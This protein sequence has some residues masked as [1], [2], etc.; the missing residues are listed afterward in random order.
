MIILGDRYEIE[1][2]AP[3]LGSG[4]MG[5]VFLGRDRQTNQSVAIKQLKQELINESPEAVERFIREADALAR[6]NHPNIVKVLATLQER[7]THY[8][9]MEYVPGGSLRSLM[10]EKGPLPLNQALHIALDLADALTRAHRLRI[11]HR[12]IKPANVLIAADGTPRLTDFGV[13]RLEDKPEMTMTGIVLGTMRYLSP[14]GL[15]G[16]PLDER[17]D[18]WSF[19]VMLYEMLAGR[20]PF[21]SDNLTQLINSILYDAPAPLHA[22]RDDV[23]AELDALILAMLV[24]DREDRISSVRQVGLELEALLRD[25]SGDSSLRIQTR[26]TLQE[27]TPTPPQPIPAETIQTEMMP[28][29]PTQTSSHAPAVTAEMGTTPA[30]VSA[31][32]AQ[33]TRGPLLVL[34]AIV[35]LALVGGLLLLLSGGGAAP[36]ATP[37]PGIVRGL[38]QYRVLVARFEPVGGVT[39]RDVSAQLVTEIRRVFTQE[40]PYALIDVVTHPEM[41]VGDEQVLRVAEAQQAALVIHGTYSATGIQVDISLGSLHDFP[42]MAFERAVLERLINVRVEIP[43]EVSQTIAPQIASGLALLA[44]ADGGVFDW[45]R[46]VAVANAPEAPAASQYRATASAEVYRFHINYLRNPQSALQSIDRAITQD[47]S[48]ALLYWLRGAALTREY[49]RDFADS[50]VDQ[51]QNNAMRDAANRNHET[52]RRL[53]PSNWAAPL[54][55]RYGGILS[56]SRFSDVGLLNSGTEIQQAASLRPNDWSPLYLLSELA[57]QEGNLEEARLYIEKALSIRPRA[58]MPYTTAAIIA[59]RSGRLVDALD[60]IQRSIRELPDPL[61]TS[62]IFDVLL[63]ISMAESVLPAIFSNLV[64][65][66]FERATQIA[67]E[68]YVGRLT[69]R[70]LFNNDVNILLMLGVSQCS[71]GNFQGAQLAFQN[72]V[73]T[74]GDF[75]LA[76]LLRASAY[77]RLNNTERAERE[78]TTIAAGPQAELLLPYVEALRQGS[79]TCETIFNLDRVRSITPEPP[80]PGT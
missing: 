47:S 4:G 16:M 36:D 44:L 15:N 67:Q 14:E 10:D 74:Q 57:L 37:T 59:L 76:R 38:G 41:L 27:L 78:F 72:V 30:P 66:Q 60:L 68:F 9:V 25:L 62:Y 32:P 64:I 73:L 18:I 28:A 1:D 11:V 17:A 31:A 65:G 13:A 20:R 49:I 8:I 46:M 70:G 40:A 3:S 50:Q 24:K 79:L 77:L 12:D 19:G 42:T 52:A 58:G 71:L 55:S 7:D 48:S 69:S 5:D 26:R 33:R 56:G 53:G 80:A 21:E 43:D 29:I 23:P 6:L 51:V 61:V 75:H 39:A 22:L 45:A 63:G 54:Y 34:L 2:A 35:V